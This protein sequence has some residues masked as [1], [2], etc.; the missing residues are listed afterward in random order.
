MTVARAAVTVTARVSDMDSNTCRLIIDNGHVAAMKPQASRPTAVWVK[1]KQSFQ[2]PKVFGCLFFLVAI[3]ANFKTLSSVSTHQFGAGDVAYLSK[4]HS[5]N[6]ISKDRV[7]NQN[8]ARI[9]LRDHGDGWEITPFEDKTIKQ[10]HGSAS[11]STYT[12]RWTK[13]RSAVTGKIVD[14][15][16]HPFDDI[17]SEKIIQK[18]FWGGC[19]ILPQLWNQAQDKSDVHDPMIY[20][21]VG[22]NV[23]TPLIAGS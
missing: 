22:A 19:T 6:I 23:S 10:N 18:N 15:C 9:L 2:K 8:I 7:P 3:I 4:H 12:C 14:M 5:D 13:F 1:V 16:V 20:L 17:I 11:S 21:D